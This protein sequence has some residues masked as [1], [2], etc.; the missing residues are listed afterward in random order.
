MYPYKKASDLTFIKHNP[1]FWKNNFHSIKIQKG[2]HIM[3]K[4]IKIH[5]TGG[6]EVM[7]W[8]DFD[9][10]QPGSA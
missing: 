2:E 7:R 6:P 3:A 10:G 4:A 1:T 5:E 9:P 8:E